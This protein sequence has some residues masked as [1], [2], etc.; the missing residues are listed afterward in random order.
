VF[1]NL[2]GSVPDPW[3]FDTFPDPRMRTSD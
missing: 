3:H 1:C 2:E